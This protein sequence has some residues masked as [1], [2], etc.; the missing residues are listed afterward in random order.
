MQALAVVLTVAL[1][2]ALVV[3]ARARLEGRRRVQAEIDRLARDAVPREE[4]SEALASREALL[5][6][7]DEPA[8]VFAADGRLLRANRAARKQ[9]PELVADEPASQLAEPVAA[10][11]A[12]GQKRT[13][14]VTVYHPERRRYRAALQPYTTR[15][16]QACVVVLA[17]TSAQDDYRDAR[18]LFSAGVSHELRTPLAR[19]LALVDTL[20]L[21][22]AD[23]E[24][25]GVI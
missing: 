19:I 2:V 21:P 10:C 14:D 17:D 6:G 1:G 15:D 7:L 12:S 16:G 8:L 18:R 20:A 24:R 5:T 25:D 22:L 23:A 3:A 9:V 11:I 13:A 4:L